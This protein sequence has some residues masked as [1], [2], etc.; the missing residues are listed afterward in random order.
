MDDQRKAGLALFA[1]AVQFAVGL[2][3]AEIEYPGYDMS[4]NFISNLGD[5]SDSLA[6]TSA[7]LFNGS[8][9]LLGASILVTSWFLFRSI[10]DR[11][12]PIVIA[13]A[14]IGAIGVGVFPEGEGNPLRLQ[15]IHTIFSFIAFFFSALSALVA[16]RIV[17]A[18][19]NYLSVLLGLA[20]LVALGFFATGIGDYAGLGIGGME[21]MVVWPVLTWAIAFGGYLLATPP[22]SERA[23]S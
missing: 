17:R 22:G 4:E 23:A 16:F 18:P 19:L 8:I 10:V 20:S 3:L 6:A 14:G 11:V 12:F 21:R 13:L 15:I 2:T 9:I 5:W 7:Y 1:G